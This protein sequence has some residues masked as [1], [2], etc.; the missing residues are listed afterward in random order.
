MDG[1]PYWVRGSKYSEISGDHLPQEQ[2]PFCVIKC[3]HLKTQTISQ[4]LHI[5]YLLSITVGV[6]ISVLGSGIT[7]KMWKQEWKSRASS[8]IL[9]AFVDLLNPLNR[10]TVSLQSCTLGHLAALEKWSLLPLDWLGQ[11][12][13]HG[14]RSEKPWWWHKQSIKSVGASPNQPSN[15]CCAKSSATGCENM[16]SAEYLAF[17]R[18]GEKPNALELHGMEIHGIT[19]TSL[20]AAFCQITIYVFPRFDQGVYPCQTQLH[21]PKAKIDREL[22]LPTKQLQSSVARGENCGGGYDTGCCIWRHFYFRI[23]FSENWA[24]TISVVASDGGSN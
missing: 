5:H 20:M 12:C 15:L 9:S 22:N 23:L 8:W 2:L 6:I 21:D 11:T 24:V 17:H 16:E 13:S 1:T 3:S 14:G 10:I 19:S 4:Q 7:W 18:S